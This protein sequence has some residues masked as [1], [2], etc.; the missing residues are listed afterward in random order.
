MTT[1]NPTPGAGAYSEDEVR[2]MGLRINGCAMPPEY[3]RL[4]VATLQ[5]P[6]AEQVRRWLATLDAERARGE[7]RA[8]SVAAYAVRMARET[9]D[10][11]EWQTA[12]VWAHTEQEIVSQS[13]AKARGL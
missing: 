12:P 2:A 9:K 8:V 13:A 7:A 10:T 6:Q 11:G 1:P 3:Q 4:S 5:A